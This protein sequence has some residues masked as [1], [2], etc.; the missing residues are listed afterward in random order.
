MTPSRERIEAIFDAAIDLPTERRAEWLETACKG[1]TELY[2]DVLALIEAHERTEGILELDPRRVAETL[3]PHIDE[4]RRI[5]PYRVVHELGRG[6]MG[7]VYLA[8]REDG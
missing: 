4:G 3:Q 8:V 6:G 1:D 7:V 5:G 2:A